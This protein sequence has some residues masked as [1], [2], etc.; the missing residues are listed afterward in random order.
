MSSD[1]NRS[2]QVAVAIIPKV[3]AALSI[4]G[5]SWIMIE[6]LTQKS[7]RG[8]VYNRLLCTMSVFDFTTAAWMFASSWPV[9]DGSEGVA[10][11]IGNQVTCDVQGFFMQLGIIPR[12]CESNV[13]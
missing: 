1:F 11:A 13:S 8:N 4:F 3:S 10:F 5:S 9:P 12:I 7:K 2:Q 6:V